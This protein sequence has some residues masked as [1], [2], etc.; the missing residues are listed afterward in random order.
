MQNGAAEHPDLLAPE[1]AKVEKSK[2]VS[3]RRDASSSRGKQN[4]WAVLSGML[5]AAVIG[6]VLLFDFLPSNR[7]VLAEGDVSPDDISAPAD[8][9]YVSEIRTRQAQDAQ[10]SAVPKFYDPPD[11]SIARQQEVRAQQILAYISTVRQDTYASTKEKAAWIA[12]IPDLSLEP[13]VSELVL[14]MDGENWQVV[15]AGTVDVLLNAMEQ[16]IR[17]EDLAGL[18]RGLANSI[19]LR[20]TDAQSPVVEAL[21]KGLV[22]PNTFYNAA[23]TEEARQS[24]RE[25]TTPVSVTIRQGEAIIRAGDLVRPIDIEELD[26]FGLHQPAMRWQSLV[27]TLLFSLLVTVLI[28]LCVVRFRPS[29]WQ[30]GR[31]ALVTVLLV[32]LFVI[33]AKLM[34]P[35][36]DTVAPYLYPLPTLS[37]ILT[38]LFGP[39]LGISVGAMVGLVGSFLVGA[40]PELVTYLMAGTLIG[41]LVLGRAERLKSFLQAGLVVALTNA[42]VIILFG[43]LLPEQDTLK[44]AINAVVGIVMGGLAASLALAAFFALSALLDIVTPFQ[45]MEL[46]RPTH[47]LFRQLL[48]KAPGTYHHTLLV[49]NMAEEA[50]NRIG[51]DGLLARVGSY[52]HDIGKTVRPFFFT[53]N[54]VGGANPHERLDPRTSA[55]IIISHVQDGQ[56]LAAKYRLPSAVSAFIP[57]HQGE[58]L[59]LLSHGSTDGGR[60]WPEC[61]RGRFPLSRP[62]TPKQRDGDCH[63]GR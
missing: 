1:A 8:L 37:M 36:T 38:I 5:L 49:A 54:R 10:A 19:A 3:I 2:K 39:A 30:Q 32:A 29:I 52:Y 40:S 50:A 13:E 48:L 47:P 15:K 43:L 4:L 44:V 11:S 41:A 21:V 9:T 51:A 59:V 61:P 22:V 63:A 6:A 20:F 53:E 33:G 55:Q 17:D 56:E 35:F 57:E 16:E 27:G 31:T 24:A 46:S 42:A 62:Q 12:A 18:R 58:G 34:L 26:A 60:R 28:E 25:K 7:V 14:G 23:R 45:L